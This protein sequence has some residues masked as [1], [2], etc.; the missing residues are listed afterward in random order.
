MDKEVDNKLSRVTVI[1]RK[2]VDFGLSKRLIQ[3]QE[4]DQ[5]FAQLVKW[6]NADKFWDLNIWKQGKTYIHTRFLHQFLTEMK[7]QDMVMMEKVMLRIIGKSIASIQQLIS[8]NEE[9]MYH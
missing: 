5:S 8:S 1:Q 9:A 4:E 6:W 7:S 3:K 2:S